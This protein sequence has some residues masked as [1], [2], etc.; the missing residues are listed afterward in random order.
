MKHKLL[1]KYLQNGQAM[2]TLLFFVIVGITVTSAATIIIMINSLS[3]NKLQQ[4]LIVYSSAEAGIE[5]ALLRLLRDPNYKGETLT[6][7]EGNVEVKVTGSSP[8]IITS[9]A[10][11]GDLLRK[12][13]VQTQYTNNI[14]TVSSWKEVF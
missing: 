6:I 10:K 14:L 11:E 3:T 1:I 12:I 2:I 7:G 9:Q 13:E 8:I 4:G 5:N